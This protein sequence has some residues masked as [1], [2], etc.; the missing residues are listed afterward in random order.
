M[1]RI[2]SSKPYELVLNPVN[3]VNPVQS[4]FSDR[5]NGMDRI[6]SSKP[7]ELVLNPVNHVNPVQSL[8]QAGLTG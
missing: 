4:L 2:E 5:I 7:Y 3:H 6:E 8:F 1:A